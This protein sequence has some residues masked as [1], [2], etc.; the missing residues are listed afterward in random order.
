MSH[1]VCAG[2][3]HA[4]PRDVGG[5]SEGGT[6][7]ASPSAFHAASSCQTPVSPPRQSSIE[8]GGCWHD[9]DDDDD[10]GD[11]VYDDDDEDGDGDDDV[12]SWSSLGAY[13]GSLGLLW[14]SRAGRLRFSW[15]VLGFS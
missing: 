3:R 11:A 5:L 14:G 8:G 7:R 1:A 10:D 4:Q 2:I 12:L 6:A 9:D 15:V 13:Q